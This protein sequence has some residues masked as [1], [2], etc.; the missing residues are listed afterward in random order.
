MITEQLREA[1]TMSGRSRYALAKTTGIDMSTL[2][3]FYWG[4]GNLSAGGIDLMAEALGLELRPKRPARKTMTR[5]T[6]KAAKRPTGKR[7]SKRKGGK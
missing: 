1:M 5:P 3:R 4:T 6:R 2:Y 7:T